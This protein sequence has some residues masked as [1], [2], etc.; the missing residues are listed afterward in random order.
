MSR[1]SMNE[2]FNRNH[3]ELRKCSSRLLIASARPIVRLPHNQPRER[4]AREQRRSAAIV[5]ADVAGYSG[6][7]GT[8]ESRT[9]ADLKAHR[10][11]THRPESGTRFSARFRPPP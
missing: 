3:G 2:D 4:M 10:R 5:S 7:A 6:L 1:L 8:D 11:E 9:L